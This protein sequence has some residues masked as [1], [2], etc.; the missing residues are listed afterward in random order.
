MPSSVG[1]TPTNSDLLVHM[2]TLGLGLQPTHAAY[3]CT[4]PT[5]YT[6]TR[7][8]AYTCTRPIAYTCTRPIAY[9]CTRPTACT[10]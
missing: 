3:T 5:A 4:R 6:C 8:I 7:P 2:V 1:Q 9:T 10:Y